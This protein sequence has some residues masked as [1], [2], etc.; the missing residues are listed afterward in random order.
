MS[1]DRPAKNLF[2]HSKLRLAAPNPSNPKAKWCNLEIGLWQNNPRFILRTNDPALANPQ[3]GFGNFTVPIELPTL[4]AVAAL[5]KR[6]LLKKEQHKAGVFE[7]FN[8]PKGAD[9]SAPPVHIASIVVG[10]DAE[11]A[12]FIALDIKEDGWPRIAFNF[13]PPDARFV[14]VKA[15]TGEPF[16]KQEISELYAEAY[17]N[18][19]TVGA[20]N[21]ANTHY[22]EPQPRGG[23][24][25]YGNNRGGGGNNYGNR[26][27]QGG[28]Y[29]PKSTAEDSVTDDDLPF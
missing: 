11:G 21:V 25:G 8:K 23:Q 4:L 5:I 20:L 17:I 1:S 2:N 3:K 15:G 16:T 28:G 22:V 29:A 24:G 9:F 6:A 14:K 19:L 13:A 10:R 26:G 12:V 7:V 27:G 18:I